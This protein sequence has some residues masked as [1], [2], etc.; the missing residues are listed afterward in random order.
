MAKLKVSELFYSIQGEGRYAGVPSLFLRVFGC[1]LRCPGFSRDHSVANTPNPE[2]AALIQRIPEFKEQAIPFSR[3]PLSK[4]GCDTYAAV[5]PEF[6]DFSPMMATDE[7]A[8]KIKEVMPGQFNQNRHLVITG[9]EPLLPGWQ[10]AYPD[11]ISSILDADLVEG[12]R[13]SGF[14]SVTFETN[15]TQEVDPLVFSTIMWHTDLHFSVSVKMAA[16]GEI[17]TDTIKPQCIS[18]Y[19][20]HG[21]VDFKFVVET[22][23]HVVEVAKLFD[24]GGEF[25]SFKDLAIYLMPVGGTNEVYSGNRRQV[26]EAC[27]KYGFRYS[28]RL[29]ND[30]FENEWGT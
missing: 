7:V 2:V 29:Q 25:H 22:P 1:N 4:T 3:L 5:Y 10:K 8:A 15:G 28:P 14:V 19:Y 13:D 6:K 23:E 21:L 12:G 11:L 16:S 24:E 20:D 9:G 30:L 26:A 27:M 18:G 17:R